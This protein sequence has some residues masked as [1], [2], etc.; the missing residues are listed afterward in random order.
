[1]FR[2]CVRPA[3]KPSQSVPEF[4]T[5]PIQAQALSTKYECGVSRSTHKINYSKYKNGTTLTVSVANPFQ[6]DILFDYKDIKSFSES[7]IKKKTNCP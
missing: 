6:G 5:I 2:Y 1:L 4:N 3:A 7:A